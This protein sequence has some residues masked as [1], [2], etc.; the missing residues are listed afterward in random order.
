MLNNNLDESTLMPHG[1]PSSTYAGMLPRAQVPPFFKIFAR[2]NQ[3][4][5]EEKCKML[6]IN[7]VIS[8][9]ALDVHTSLSN[10]FFLC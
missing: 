7:F 2:W 3:R 4:N 8:T 10:D 9:A 1:L 6:K 5:D